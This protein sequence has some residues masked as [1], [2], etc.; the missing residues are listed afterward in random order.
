MGQ[1]SELGGLRILNAQ[2]HSVFQI[3]S[4]VLALKKDFS[5]CGF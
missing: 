3:S 4:L 1:I 5:F 2:N